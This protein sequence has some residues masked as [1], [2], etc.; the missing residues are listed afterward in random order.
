LILNRSYRALLIA[1]IVLIALSPVPASAVNQLGNVTAWGQS[2]SALTFDTTGGPRLRL[3]FLSD[4]LFLCR[5]SPDGTFRENISRAVVKKDW[6]APDLTVHDAGA[7]VRVTTARMIVEVQKV[8]C[9]VS[10]KDLQGNVVCTDHSSI[11]IL[12]DSTMTRVYKATQPGETY[13]GLGWRPQG[14]LKRNGTKFT[15]RNVPTYSEPEVFYGGI[16]FWYGMRNGSAYG[17]FFD[18]TSWGEINAGQQS[19]SSMYFANLGGQLDYYFFYGPSISGILDRYTELT[20]R[21][22]LPPKWAAGYQQCRWS[23]YPQ[24][25]LLNV[26][27]TFREKNI[28]C[29]VMYLDIDYMDRGKQ[30]TFNPTAFP[31]PA[32][33]NAA[34]HA[35]GFHTVANIGPWLLEGSPKYNEAAAQGFLLKKPDG[36]PHKF[37]HDYIHFVMGAP[38]GWMSEVD[39]TNPAARAWYAGKH[40]PFLATGIDG[41]WNDLNEPDELGGGAWPTDVKYNMEGSPADHNKTSPQYSLFQ[42]QFSYDVLKDQWPEGR[43]FVLS[44]AAYAGIQRS[45]VV[46][47]GDNTSDWVDHFR[48]NIPMGLSMSLSGQPLNGHDIG[49][50]MGYPNG[51]SPVDAELFARWMQAGVFSAFC[52]AHHNGNGTQ[53]GPYAEPWQF[54][55]QVENI[56]RDYISLRYRLMP[57]LYSLFFDAHTSGAPIQRPTLYD[58]QSD[59]NTL[60]QDYDFMFGP[61]MLIAPVHEKGAMSRSVYLP[62]GTGWTYWW[63]GQRYTGGQTVIVSAPLNVM[64]IFVRDGA[65]IPMGPV[66]QYADE[67]PLTDLTLKLYPSTVRETSFRLFEDDGKSFGYQSGSMALTWYRMSRGEETFVLDI[68]PREGSFVPAPRHCTAE[69]HGWD[70]AQAGV[71]LTGQPLSRY[72][73]KQALMAADTGYYHDA[74]ASVLYVRFPETGE[75]QY[76]IAGPDYDAPVISDLSTAGFAS[77]GGVQLRAVASDAGSGMA[78]VEFCVSGELLATVSGEQP[79]GQYLCEW[80]GAGPGNHTVEARAFDTRGNQSSKYIDVTVCASVAQFKDAPDGTHIALT[81]VAP[82]TAVFVLGDPAMKQRYVYA[83]DFSRASGIRVLVESTVASG[84]GLMATGVI[85]AVEF[86][87]KEQPERVLDARAPNGGVLTSPIFAPARPLGLTPGSLGPLNTGLLVRVWGRVDAVGS[88]DGFPWLSLADG[89]RLSPAHSLLAEPGALP[90]CFG[91][92][93]YVPT[94]FAVKAGDFV[95]VE[96]I[97]GAEAPANFDQTNRV[98]RVDDPGRVT[99]VEPSVP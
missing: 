73:T 77:G 94:T 72:D 37:W 6:D 51:Q 34:L 79:G 80:S 26:A 29:D 22:M 84:E 67:M 56:C 97:S 55:T 24:S 46:W 98:I 38:T 82:V 4:D 58:F 47:S 78:R 91:V 74:T 21:P 25:E 93:A 81:G 92:R 43:P 89:S 70:D 64:P 14:G 63:T 53:G 31:D 3:V 99:V 60:T 41:I 59:A 50:F 85:R 44:R 76:V 86:A 68:S 71:L 7:V 30:L 49:G 12:W 33:M 69:I 40:A 5:F 16:P 96:G 61:W 9:V 28:P 88:V 48:Q 90:D 20:G 42:T 19:A 52:R 83:Q 23:Y 75:G 65:I 17:I 39:F 36:Q 32:G 87:G 57:Y 95:L 45:A 8:P 27:N 54:G 2:G 18:D 35:Q 15:M 1:C 13:L 66:M 62:A 10:V 11:R